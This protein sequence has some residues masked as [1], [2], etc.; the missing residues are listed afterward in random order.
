MK[1]VLFVLALAS[2]LVLSAV[3]QDRSQERSKVGKLGQLNADA[4][5]YQ[6]ADTR[7]RVLFRAKAQLYVVLTNISNDYV[8]VVMADGSKGF[9]EAKYVDRLPYDVG[10]DG[11]GTR[12]ETLASRQLPGVEASRGGNFRDAGV[13][14]E[15]WRETVLRS[16]M[17]YQGTKYVFGG[18]DL[19]NGID[20]SGFVRELYKQVGLSLPRIAADQISVGEVVPAVD[21]LRPGDRLYF[22][23]SARQRI[24]HTG[25]YMGNGYF[26]HASSSAGQVTVTFLTERWLNLLVGAR[27]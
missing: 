2:A 12:K 20:C 18:N 10:Y 6:K 7:S 15:G 9:I 23:N 25:L 5:I 13:A 3:A 17:R 22:T 16:A 27:R 8:A 14:A 4:P 11:A 24:S 19:L 26:I 1:R 21:Q